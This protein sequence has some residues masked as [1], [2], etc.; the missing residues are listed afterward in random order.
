VRRVALACAAA[1][2][3][4]P[5][6]ARADG[7]LSVSLVKPG[8]GFLVTDA[9]QK[10]PIELILRDAKGPVELVRAEVK[11]G[12]GKATNAEV[13]G[14]GRVVFLYT[15]PERSRTGSDMLDLRLVRKSG[16]DIQYAVPLELAA[17]E[18]PKLSLELDPT[19]LAA[20]ERA[21]IAVRA[22]ASGVAVVRTEASAGSLV[23]TGEGQ[24]SLELPS[25]LPED[26]PS[27]VLVV[28]T[29]AGPRGWAARGAGLSVLAELRVSTMDVEPGNQLALEGSENKVPPVVAAA[30]GRTVIKDLVR[31]GANVRAF[32][33]KGRQR[34]EIP[35]SVPSGLVPIALAAAIPGQDVADGGSGPSIVVAAPP[36]PFGGEITWPELRVEGATLQSVRDVPGA[37]DLKVLVLQRPR[38]PRAVTVLA[39]GVKI[40]NVP[41]GA[42]YGEALRA[43][44]VAARTGERAAVLVTV[45]DVFGAPADKPE[46]RARLESGEVLPVERV[47]VGEHRVVVPA[48]TKGETGARV[49]LSAEIPPPKSLTDEPLELPRVEVEVELRG[50][51]PAVGVDA[52]RASE[53]P[54]PVAS[55]SGARGRLG[56]RPLVTVGFGLAGPLFV[57]GGLEVEGV[58]PVFDD[59]L[60]IALGLEGQRGSTSGTLLLNGTVEQPASTTFG[61]LI[62]PLVLRFV[63]L[64]LEPVALA[65]LIG[66]ELRVESAALDVGESRAGGGSRVGVGVRAGAEAQFHLGPGDLLVGASVS[67]LGA[68]STFGDTGATL[69]S[70]VTSVRLDLGYRLWVF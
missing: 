50:A 9:R 30:D 17:P 19:R 63:A 68:G 27:H 28:A 40:A 59:R 54:P 24:S 34:K 18:Q 5:V 20:T 7:E 8:G 64:E 3:L 2:A 10:V 47:G 4:A 60:S 62:V 36:P 33:V 25:D 31:Y 66:A 52:P 44:V 65:A 35:I 57:G 6:A 21:P 45:T 53:T 1:L 11:A 29:A 49:R 12:Q 15:P 14:K 51:P 48:G 55:A 67:G 70:S 56:L 16:G 69:E 22:Q 37:R 42:A 46:P 38:A 43:E 26:A 58:L 39:D 41:F 13:V 61:A 23:V 32:S